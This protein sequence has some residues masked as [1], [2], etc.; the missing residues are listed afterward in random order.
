MFMKYVHFEMGAHT[1]MQVYV[2]KDRD[3]LAHAGNLI[4]R[5][6]EFAHFRES[7]SGETAITTIAFE[8]VSV[9]AKSNG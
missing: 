3:H 9:K 8:D 6:D 7:V 5:T 1:H 4:M 2:G